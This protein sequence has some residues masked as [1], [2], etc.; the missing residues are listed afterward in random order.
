VSETAGTATRV[1]RVLAACN[2]RDLTLACLRSLQAQRPPGVTLDPFV[3]EP[4]T[5][6]TCASHPK[7]RPGEQPLGDEL[8]RLWSIKELPPGPWAVYS[9][10][11]AGRLW[12]LYWLG[13]YL[14]RGVQLALERTPLGRPRRAMT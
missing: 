4:G 5:V 8:R 1:A 9:R 14:R 6:G 13:P 7:R 12:P 10:R 11:W 2:R 3:V